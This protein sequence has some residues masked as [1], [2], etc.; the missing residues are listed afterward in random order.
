MERNYGFGLDIGI[1][2]VGWAV[3]SYEK[4]NDARIEDFGVRLFDSGE[5]PKEKTS[6]SQ[7][8]R[9][10]RS[11]R[12]L[13]R[14]RRHRKDRA[15]AFMKTI[16]LISEE[17]L[18]AWQETNGNQ[19]IFVV[20]VKGL[21]EKLTP[22]EIA[23]CVIHISN[24]R[25][26]REFYED[27]AEDKKEAGKI[28]GGLDAFDKTYSEGNYKSV[29]EMIL[30]DE[31][32]ATKTNF[33]DYHNHKKEN[34]G[35]DG[36]GYF[37]IKRD[38]LR[39]ELMA[40]LQK[41]QEYYPQLTDH[42]IR[43]LCD[44]IVFAQRDFEDGPGDKNDTTRKFMG[45]LDTVGKCMYYK[46]EP[47]G[48]RSTIIGD[49]YSMIN[50]LSQLSFVDTETGAIT[51]PPDTAKRIISFALENASITEKD[52]VGILKDNNL[53]MVK[54]GKMTEKL[55]ETIKTLKVLKKLLD[56]SGYD[57]NE[58]IKEEQFDAEKP[59]KLHQLCYLMASNITP[60]RRR[61]ELARNGWNNKMQEASQRIRFSGTANVSDKYMIEA[62]NAFMLGETYGNYQARRIK[63]RVEEQQN[64]ERQIFLA[65]FTK[66]MDED[67]V[68]NIVVFKSIN[69]TRKIINALVR[70][71]GSPAYI[72]IEVADELGHNIETRNKIQKN[73]NANKKEKEDIA[74]HIV[75]LGLRKEGEVS[76]RDILGYRLWQSQDG[77]DLYTGKNI[78]IED[79]FKGIYDIDHIIP[80]SLILDDTVQNKVLTDRAS[81]R[82]EKSNKVPC[83][84]LSGDRLVQF[85]KHVN[86][87]LKNKKISKTKYRYLMLPD[88]NN[89]DILDEWKSR[90]LNDTRYITRYLVN[91]LNANLKFNSDKA[92][93]VYAVKGAITSRMRKVWLNKRTWGSEEKNRDNN[94][95]HA[96]DA[97]VIAN[98]TPA[99]VEIASDNLKLQ[100]LF[101]QHKKT[102]TRE[103]EE[104]LQKA[105]KKMQKYYGYSPEYTKSLLSHK[106]RIP[107]MVKWLRE[108]TDI[109]LVDLSLEEYASITEES[110][111]KNVREFYKEDLAFAEQIELPLVSYKQNNKFS[112]A[113]T[114]AN[115]V[116]AK[117]NAT[118]TIIKVDSLGNNNYL[119][120]RSYYCL[121]L[122]RNSK[123][124]L[125]VRGIRYADFVKKNK[126][127][128]LNI[129]YP[130]DYQ[131][132]VMYLSAA[133]YVEIFDKNGKLKV[134]GFYSSIKNIKRSML[135]FRER[136]TNGLQEKGIALNDTIKKYSVDIL[137][138]IGGEIKC[139]AQFSSLPEGN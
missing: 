58:L 7:D 117:D 66:S 65:P 42:N 8:R 36:R 88:L 78:D 67:L 124:L 68:K 104:Y 51:L 114:A 53:E 38:A 18:K 137:G 92:K 94:L 107:S 6:K 46:D 24:H 85:K 34:D 20:R 125:K 26:Y 4:K 40:I 13:I 89:T 75:E 102:V 59:S 25:G 105:V 16:K 112:G 129:P 84:F 49:V 83:E 131:T 9:G 23:D 136:N 17:K 48:F 123:G 90:N 73:I 55:P 113:Y 77:I 3:L 29:A 45:F 96:A 98:L 35:Q 31:H 100:Q 103:Y 11:V 69:E 118:G 116:K 54:P 56:E 64:I 79:I 10:F 132:H 91:Y 15:I 128:W 122:Y 135:Y 87:L 70:K 139:S 82:Q 28:K 61:K 120:A 72:N 47:R 134:K 12:R 62:I 121:E 115:P 43:F 97:I 126:K 71:Y 74:K 76:G 138:K 63:E 22:E 41:Q 86:R 39:E 110:F 57:Y 133:D 1:G 50:F 5:K 14:R 119:D 32:F 106:E 80:F 19:N 44:N 108:E 27:D 21:S 93:N 101:R 127:L 109:R 111:K 33:P 2:S 60:K 37:L 30:K 52:V 95:H 99:A 130:E 81:N